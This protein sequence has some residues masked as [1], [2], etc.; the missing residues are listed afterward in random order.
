MWPSI[1]TKGCGSTK[2]NAQGHKTFHKVPSQSF[3]IYLKWN[4][5]RNCKSNKYTVNT[6]LMVGNF[7]GGGGG[8]G[9]EAVDLNYSPGEKYI[10]LLSAIVSVPPSPVTINERGILNLITCENKG[11]ANDCEE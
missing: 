9:G 2:P 6:H 3:D 1:T 8:W 11:N 7:N 4:N 10:V 5:N